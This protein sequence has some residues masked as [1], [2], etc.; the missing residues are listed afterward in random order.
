MPATPSLVT[1]VTAIAE[2]FTAHEI[3]AGDLA[4]QTLTLGA[5][6]V[7]VTASISPNFSAGPTAVDPTKNTY[8]TQTQYS[9]QTVN[10]PKI[11]VVGDYILV[12]QFTGLVYYIP[13][14]QY[15]LRFQ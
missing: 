12:S 5:Y 10:G 15:S 13:Q 8:P 6:S 3:V 1:T 4:A 14:A 9:I 11:L 2:K 7:L